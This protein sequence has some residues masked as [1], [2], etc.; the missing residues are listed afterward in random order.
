MIRME[1]A[2]I[3]IMLFIAGIYFKAAR[4][5]SAIHKI[6]SAILVV[7]P[8]YL[9]FDAITVL[10]VARL[11]TF[12]RFWNDTFHRIYLSAMLLTIYL[13]Y[14][15]ICEL[16][17]QET[18]IVEV[19]GL[20]KV[21][22][23]ILDVYLCIAELLLYVTP[24][25]YEVTPKG[26]YEAGI[27]AVILYVSVA[28]FLF[29]MIWNTVKHWKQIHS[30]K[31][32]VII[33]AFS[34]E[35]VVTVLTYIDMS[36]L[37][38]GMGLTLI[39][40]S[41][42]LMLENPDIRLLELAREERRKADEANASK[43]A[44]LSVVSHEIRTPMNAIVG[45]SELLL[46]ENLSEQ[47]K[48]Y[49]KS[50]QTSGDSLLTIVN[51][52]LD[53]S[54]IEAGIIEIVEDV[55]DLRELLQEIKMII[56]NR[57]D[58]KPI[59]ILI[60][61]DKDIP[62]VMIGDRLRVRQVLINLMN[63]AVK[64][65]QEGTITLAISKESE[66][67]SGMKLRYSVTD[68]GQGI[69]EEDLQHLFK[70]FS[71]VDRKRNHNKEGTGLG[72]SI[73]RTFIQLMGGELSVTSEYG[74]GSE[75]FFT[76]YQRKAEE[77]E[78]PNPQRVDTDN[79]IHFIA[80]EARI[81][82]VDDT[83]INRKIL[84]NLLKHVQ[85]Q[86]DEAESGAEAIERIKANTYNIIFMDYN[87]PYMDGVETTRRIRNLDES[88]HELGAAGYFR[89]VPIIALTGDAFDE[90]RTAFD[91]AGI[92]DY[93]EKPVVRNTLMKTLYKWLPEEMILE[94]S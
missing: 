13:Y 8:I 38:A 17:R 29:H 47:G 20:N 35:I 92:N 82:A 50:I 46:E 41:F 94:D 77:N 26:N 14:R 71:Q 28:L 6:Y 23:K 57:I 49:V 74:K 73:S 55:Y 43:S 80:P 39:A 76:L 42:F 19:S 63:N 7:L 9:V 62:A 52:L 40:V 67:E 79:N 44:F 21:I 56:E 37:L 3:L 32:D 10:T 5:K 84:K 27:G 75:F 36:L 18:Q 60:H 30:Q 90:S 45:M 2:C 12:P 25:S 88:Q 31:R 53:Q 83:S 24:V 70:A 87:M 61:V 16:I 33:M 22:Y 78:N 15:Y 93:L 85:A 34:I 72:L 89:T 54:K 58:S 81:L 11:D 48:M 66:D 4:E 91:E 1:I 69:R 59:Q 68:T 65:T 64:F 86:I 51:E